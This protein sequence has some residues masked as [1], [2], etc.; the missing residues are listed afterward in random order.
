MSNYFNIH[1]DWSMTNHFDYIRKTSLQQDIMMDHGPNPYVIDIKKATEYN[2]NYRTTLWT[3]PNMQLTVMS[4]P[5]GEDIG[6]ELHPQVEQFLRIEKGH[7]IVQMGD[8]KDH[9][10]FQQQ[11]FDDSA[12]FIPS[13]TWH[14]VINIG[15]EP[16]KLY[17]IYA[18]ANHPHGAIH[19]TKAIAEQMEGH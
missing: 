13:G 10:H 14:N 18:P 3:G 11:V 9:L 5:V 12:I 16:L 8:R 1:P 7:G 15:N 17:A 4:I 19:K 2:N 6:L